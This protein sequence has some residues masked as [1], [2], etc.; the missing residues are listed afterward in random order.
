LLSLTERSWLMLD[1]VECLLGT[2]ASLDEI[3][4]DVGQTLVQLT[5]LRAAGGQIRRS[6]EERIREGI[7]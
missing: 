6:L 4:E 5:F 3:A 7:S 2:G 1:R